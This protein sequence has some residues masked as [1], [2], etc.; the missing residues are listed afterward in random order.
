MPSI[1]VAI[2]NPSK[3]DTLPNDGRAL[4]L[5]ID[6]LS[7]IGEE[8][9]LDRLDDYVFAPLDQIEEFLGDSGLSREELEKAHPEVWYEP[10]PGERLLA[11]YIR[12]LEGYHTLSDTTRRQ[13]IPELEQFRQILEVLAKEDNFWRLEYDT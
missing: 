11:D 6:A 2:K 3:A 5:H 10:V 4:I 8:A 7:A 9:G 13:V 1:F 12:V